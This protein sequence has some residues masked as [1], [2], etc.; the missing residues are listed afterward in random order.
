MT[1][2]TEPTLTLTEKKDEPKLIRELPEVYGRFYGEEIHWHI[3]R[4]TISDTDLRQWVR[5]HFPEDSRW[6]DTSGGI[7]AYHTRA[8]ANRRQAITDFMRTVKWT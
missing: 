3:G 4:E 5:N 7:V 6:R 8:Y 2:G 1:T